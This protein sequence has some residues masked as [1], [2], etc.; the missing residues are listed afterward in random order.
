MPGSSFPSDTLTFAEAIG[1]A[2]DRHAAERYGEAIFWYRRALAFRPGDAEVYNNMAAAF[3]YLNRDEEAIANYRYAIGLRP[4][5][6]RAYL[7]LATLELAR[8]RYVPAIA[9][10]R[11]TLKVD[12]ANHGARFNMGLA[13][14]MSGDGA[15]AAAS[16]R[17][18]MDQVVDPDRGWSQY[19]LALNLVEDLPADAV[20]AEHRRYGERFP[21]PE[22]VA[23]TQSREPERR[24]KVAYLSVEFR[25]HLGAGF[26]KPVLSSAD[27]RNFEVTCYCALPRHA[28]DE[29][30]AEFRTLCDV[31]TD[32]SDVS[33]SALVDRIRADRIDILVDLAG[34]SGLNRLPT[35][36]RRTAPVQITWLGYANTTGVPA[37]DYRL[38]DAITDPEGPADGL[39]SETLIRLP[40]PF[41]CFQ[42]PDRAPPLVPPPALTRGYVTF[43]SFNN[44]GKLTPTVVRLWTAVLQAVP[45]ARLLLKDRPLDCPDTAAHIRQRFADAGLDPGRLVF[46]GWTAGR[47]GH[48]A[49]YADIDIALDPF[50]YNGTITSC[51][52]LWMGVPMIALAGD[53]HAARVGASLLDAIG[54]PELVAPDARGYVERAAALAADPGRLTDLRA[55]MRQRLLRSPLCD[56]AGFARA[57][58][59]VYRDVWRRWC[60][61]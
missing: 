11:Q 3:L 33:D 21:P 37:I 45:G 20:F 47:D 23:F 27:R 38:V 56:A 55:G 7:G 48:L 9:H 17:E 44:L 58:E 12:A 19:L 26:L 32:V 54:L 2:L 53:R 52:T 42:P 46:G 34:H 8:H 10:Y 43:G 25:Q 22:A 60:A 57:L 1:H 5:Y 4:G 6:G 31:W 28:C 15:S 49:R 41:L 30:T 14:Q 18:S 13:L 16:Y 40:R 59:S 50:P 24:L 39:A 29:H 35:L 36:A 51:D 61:S